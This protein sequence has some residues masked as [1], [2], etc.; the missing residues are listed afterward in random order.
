MPPVSRI[1]GWGLAFVNQTELSFPTA[2]GCVGAA[3]VGCSQRVGGPSF[4]AKLAG[5]VRLVE[6]VVAVAQ[7]FLCVLVDRNGDRLDVLITSIV[8]Q[9][10]LTKPVLRTLPFVGGAAMELFRAEKIATVRD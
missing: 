5:A 2:R 4:A 6:E 9:L 7:R 3:W 10:H 8:A 1:L